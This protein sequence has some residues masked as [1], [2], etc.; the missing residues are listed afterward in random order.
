M[1]H[2][3]AHLPGQVEQFTASSGMCFHRDKPV[4]YSA[5]TR[6]STLIILQVDPVSVRL[7]EF[8]SASEGAPLSSQKKSFLLVKDTN[9]CTLDFIFL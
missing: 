7:P 8:L 6:D 9:I 2:Q 3:E 1:K 4:Y 5:E